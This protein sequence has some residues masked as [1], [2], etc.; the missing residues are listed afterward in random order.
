MLAV[1]GAISAKRRLSPLQKLQET[2][3]MISVKR[4]PDNFEVKNSL[5]QVE[6]HNAGKYVNPK[7]HVFSA[8]DS[9]PALKYGQTDFALISHP[10]PMP[11]PGGISYHNPLPKFW[12]EKE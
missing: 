10:D 3:G 2:R 8:T 1:T 5:A 11:N 4:V 12:A 7:T 9:E 6:Y